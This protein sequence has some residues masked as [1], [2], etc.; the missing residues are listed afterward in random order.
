MNE[1]PILNT[2]H[3]IKWNVAPF[4]PRLN[5]LDIH[6]WAVT[7]IGSLDQG[8]ALATLTNDE[9]ECAAGMASIC[10]RNEFVRCRKALRSI[11]SSYLNMPPAQ[12]G[13][14]RNRHGKPLLEPKC[15]ILH[16][17][18]THSGP[19]GLIAVC[20]RGRLGVDLEFAQELDDLMEIAVRFFSRREIISLRECSPRERLP[21]FLRY[22]TGKEA[23]IKGLG[24]TLCDNALRKIDITVRGWREDYSQIKSGWYL[25]WFSPTRES[26][27]A[28]VHEGDPEKDLTFYEFPASLEYAG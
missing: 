9:R 1:S 13:L 23:Y 8:E 19:L 27:A 11:L 20:Q 12:I 26:V 28:L 24:R 2:P 17:N 3:V 5:A 4:N 7:L 22:W 15:R 14:I 6:V 10:R 16:F 21:L 25:H 18:Q